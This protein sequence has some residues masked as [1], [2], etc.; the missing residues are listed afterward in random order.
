MLGSGIAFL[1]NIPRR[2]SCRQGYQLIWAD[3]DAYRSLWSFL[4]RHDLVGEIHWMNVPGDDPAQHILLEPRLLHT[5]VSAIA[6]GR[7]V[8]ESIRRAAVVR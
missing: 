5:Q 8:R 2:E 1:Q 3:L 4:A 7:K 6:V